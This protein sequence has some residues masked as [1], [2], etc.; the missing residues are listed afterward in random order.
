M[1]L[2][3]TELKVKQLQEELIERGATKS[4]RKR[5]LHSWDSERK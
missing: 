4:G 3:L 1:G 2:H 5:A